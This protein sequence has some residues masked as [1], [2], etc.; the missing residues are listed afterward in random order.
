MDRKEGYNFWTKSEKEE[1]R[2]MLMNWTIC[3][4]SGLYYLHS[5]KIKH[6][7]LKPDNILLKIDNDYTHPIICNE[8]YQ[9]P[10]QEIGKRCGRSADIFSMGA[11]FIEIYYI[12]GGVNKSK[13]KK[14][15]S[16]GYAKNLANLEKILSKLPNDNSMWNS[17]NNLIRTMLSEEP[18]KRM[19]AY[20]VTNELVK[21]TKNAQIP[22][23]CNHEL[24]DNTTSPISNA[25]ISN[26]ETDS[27]SEDDCERLA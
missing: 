14:L 6:R 27:D 11:I 12:L 19:N 22:I 9:S 4:A 13:L 15:I 21:I 3:I 23:L 25:S 8:Y 10:E 20:D 17:I 5:S 26:E 1:K 24:K 2:N 18:I 16:K 7:D